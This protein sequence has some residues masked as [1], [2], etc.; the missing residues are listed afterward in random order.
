V[1]ASL[2]EG[3]QPAMPA[4]A[5]V[6]NLNGLVNLEATI[7][8]DGTVKDV[9]VLSGHITLVG[10]AR[11]AVMKWRYRPATLNGRPVESKLEVRVDFQ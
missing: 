4:F 1:E 8:E 3:A 6:A 11:N 7:G 2:L 9:T 10:A 5:K